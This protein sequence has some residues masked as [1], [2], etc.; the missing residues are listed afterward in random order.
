MADR[1]L[2]ASTGNGAIFACIAPD[3]RETEP[4]VAA[5]RFAASLKPFQNETDARAALEAAGGVD[6]RDGRR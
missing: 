5:M 1:I 4:A 6:I 2:T 3:T